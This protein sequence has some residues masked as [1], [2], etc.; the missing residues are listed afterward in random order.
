[1][2]SDEVRAQ[3]TITYIAPDLIIDGPRVRSEP[4]AHLGALCR[5][6]VCTDRET[7]V[8][9]VTAYARFLAAT[10]TVRALAAKL[11]H[12]PS[13]EGSQKRQRIFVNSD[14]S[15]HAVAVAEP[16]VNPSE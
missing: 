13:R 1:M 15:T 2:G 4:D 14:G 7:A 5:A 9:Y 16:A 6:N 8:A 3:Y 12:S 11:D 10:Y